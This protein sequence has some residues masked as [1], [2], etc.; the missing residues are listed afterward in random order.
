MGIGAD[1]EVAILRLI[2]MAE[3]WAFWAD[4]TATSPETALACALHTSDPTDS[5]TQATSEAS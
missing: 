1:S 3:A 5:G 4:D 2:F